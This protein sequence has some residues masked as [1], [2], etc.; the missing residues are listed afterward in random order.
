LKKKLYSTGGI[1]KL[2]AILKNKEVQG[3]LIWC[4]VTALLIGPCILVAYRITY[5]TA[6]T[7]TRIVCG[8]FAAAILS[9]ILTWL[10]SEIW[11][12]MRRKKYEANKKTTRKA[13]RKKK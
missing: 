8:I 2:P 3:W 7:L 10:G 4:C 12:R 13:K 6:S 5:D 9:G 11:F 1:L